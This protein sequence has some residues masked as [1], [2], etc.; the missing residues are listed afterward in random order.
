MSHASGGAL[1]AGQPAGGRP[2]RV[3]TYTT[4]FPNAV[5]PVK[6]IFVE[7]RLRHLVDET[8]IESRVVAP[9]PWFPSQ[10][11]MFGA[12][13][14]FAA[15][16][17]AEQRHGVEILHPRYPVVPKVGMNIAPALLYAG[18]VGLV[19][20]IAKHW[21][22][23]LIDAHYFYPDGVA[24]AMISRDLGKPLVI[25]ARGSDVNVLPEFA[26]PRAQIRWAAGRAAGLI[27]VCQALKDRLI[28]L[29]APAGKISVLRNGV[30]L[31]ALRPMD[32]EEARRRLGV[33]GRVLL[34]VGNL[35]EL[36]GH[37]LIIESLKDFADVTLLIAGGGPERAALEKHAE[38]CGVAGRVRFLGQ[39]P[40]D[41]LA[42]IYSAADALVLASSSEGWANVL[43]EA[44][45]CGTPVVAT[46][47]SG[48]VEVVT[49]PDAGLLIDDRSAAGI[50]DG[51]RRLF[52]A[53][54]DRSAT[55][56]F[57]ELFSWDETSRGQSDLF[58][59][60]LEGRAVR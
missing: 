53:L 25:T 3:L 39:I 43:L 45:A 26:L 6:G 38:V 18:T 49:S 57:A 32:R 7:N 47:V 48:T 37:H 14:K 15:V 22:F 56:R 52:S 20:K 54:P 13:A 1:R 17:G 31:D 58:A 2:M 59:S 10:A 41:Q 21:D 23:D 12:W 11:P 8:G 24:A 44:M 46:N 55:R 28:D 60:I 29:G 27:T 35:V 9:V 42:W 36:K 50:T 51:V 16:P 34:S 40:H 5:Q 30:D 19:R 4:L 33:E